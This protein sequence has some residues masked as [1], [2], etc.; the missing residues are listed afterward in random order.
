[1]LFAIGRSA[2]TK[3]MGLEELGIKLAKNGKIIVDGS[4]QT[5]V[6][7]VF[8]LGDVVEGRLELT[9][10]AIVSGKLL[11]HRLFG[12]GSTKLDYNYIPTTIFTPL[13]YGACGYSEEDAI[14]AFGKDNVV[15][16]GSKY[17]PFE[18][19]LDD[20]VTND[21]YAKLVIH[22][23]DKDIPNRVVGIHYLGPHAGEVIQG[24]SVAVKKGISKDD[25]DI[26]IGIHPTSAEEFTLLSAIAGSADEEKK[27]CCS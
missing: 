8:A 6:N 7:N 11:V 1:M 13:E 16:Y 22:K 25:L 27:G 10:P 19:D 18:W 15:S 20:F 21:C 24:Y 26:S 3:N 9:P 12:N 14:K 17:H 2:E 23:T 4:D 5:A